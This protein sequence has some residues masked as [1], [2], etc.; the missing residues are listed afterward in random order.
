M[1][2]G[3]VQALSF[4]RARCNVDGNKKYTQVEGIAQV[5]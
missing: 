1:R 5:Y 4:Q 2:E 3:K